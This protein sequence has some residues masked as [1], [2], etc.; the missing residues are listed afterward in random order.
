MKG[1]L[2][3]AKNYRGITLTSIVSKIYNVLLLNRLEPKIEKI[4]GRT[5]MTFGEND[6]RYHKFLLSAEM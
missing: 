2:P 6:P 4:L 5:K 1:D 3:K